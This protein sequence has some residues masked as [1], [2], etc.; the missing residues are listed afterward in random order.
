[1]T[2]GEMLTK[3][4]QENHEH[5]EHC[6]IMALKQCLREIAV[7]EANH[8]A[9]QKA[10]HECKCRPVAEFDNYA[11]SDCEGLTGPI[12]PTLAEGRTKR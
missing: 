11:Y 8:A 10:L 6:K 2:D 4:Y 5:S 3:A 12:G 1:M 9:A 7:C